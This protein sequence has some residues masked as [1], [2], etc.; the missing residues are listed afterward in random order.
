MVSSFF[1]KERPDGS[2]EEV[3]GR[4]SVDPEDVAAG[5]DSSEREE[6][7]PQNETSG[8]EREEGGPDNEEN[9]PESETEWV[10]ATPPPSLADSIAS[11][12]QSLGRSLQ[13]ESQGFRDTRVTL[14]YANP[15]GLA[16]L[17]VDHPT[18]LTTL[19]RE[20][21]SAALASEG[22]AEL[23]R[24][25][26]DLRA[27][28]GEGDVHLAIGV[29]SWDGSAGEIPVL[30]RRVAISED[31]D[32]V[33]TLQ[34]LPGVELSNP[35]VRVVREA[36]AG[37]DMEALAE[38]MNGPEGF[39]PAAALE[40]IRGAGES[41]PGFTVREGL[42]LGIYTHPAAGIYR[43]LVNL[44]TSSDH[45]VV[46]A[47]S[48]DSAA[49]A[50][51]LAGKRE[52][53]LDDRDPWHEL[54]LGDQSPKTLDVI[55]QLATGL[56]A[57]VAIPGGVGQAE[58]RASI[59]A[60]LAHGGNRVAVL[61]SNAQEHAEL[62]RTFEEAQVGSIVADLS[63]F[64]DEKVVRSRLEQIA[65]G[66]F[67]LPPNPKL[68]TGR[69]RLERAR[70]ALNDYTAALHEKFEPWGVSPF[71]ALQ[72]LTDLTSLPDPPGTT[73][74]FPMETLSTIAV[75]GGQ[76]AGELLEHASALGLF[77][78]DVPL[79]PWTGVVIDNP[80][81]VGEALAALS[82]LDQEILP[83]VRMQMV[84]TPAQSGL[85]G[86]LTLRDWA[87]QLELLTRVRAV[88]DIFDP[89]VLERSPADMVVATA[90]KQWRKAR[91]ISLKGSALRSLQ[92]QARDSVRTGVHVK[93]LHAE[94][95]TAQA[96]RHQW[97]QARSSNDAVPSVPENLDALKSSLEQLED[98]L[99]EV[100]PILEPVYGELESMP[101]DELADIVAALYGD[102]EGAA[103]I[104]ELLGVLDQLDALGLHDLALDLR[105]RGVDGE[106]L[107]LELDLAW[108]ASALG[109]MLNEDPRLGGFDPSTLTRLL[110]EARDL[111]AEQ[112]RSLGPALEQR[113]WSRGM[114]ALDLY[115][116]Q[117]QQLLERLNQGESA[118]DLFA[119]MTLPWDLMPIV[120]CGP[121]QFLDLSSV[122][123]PVNSL[124]LGDL[125]ETSPG[126]L[127]PLLAR[128]GQVIAV[129]NV[130]AASPKS[131]AATLVDALPVLEL[132]RERGGQGHVFAEI[133][134]LHERGGGE[135]IVPSP[136]ATGPFDF[137]LVE[138]RGMPSADSPAIETSTAEAATVA[139][140][141][142]AALTDH[143][144]QKLA[145]VTF[146]PRHSE[147]VALAVRK[148]AEDYPQFADAL[149]AVGGVESLLNTPADL[150]AR[151]ADR[152][153]VSVGFAKTPH[154]RVIH[155]FGELSTERGIEMM[156]DLAHGLRGHVT[157]V[158]SLR[159]N[160]VDASRLRQDGERVLVDL[161]AAAESGLT[162]L[163]EAED[164]E[165]P[166]APPHLLVDLA[167]RLHSLGLR[168]VPNFGVEGGLTIPLAIG[169]PEVPNE[170]LVAV[171]TDDESYIEEPSL[172][173]RGRH[174]PSMLEQQG[175]KVH[176]ALSMAVF[177]DPN[178]EAR[179][180]VQLAL[181]AVDEY[182]TRLGLP[183]T[184]AAASALGL[185]FTEG[186]AQG[187]LDTG[188]G[189]QAPE[190]ED[191][192][193]TE[194]DVTG[195]LTILE[196][197]ATSQE[198]LETLVGE[199]GQLESV[200]LRGP[201][202]PYEPGLPLAA[203]SDDQLDEMARWILSDGEDRDD[204]ALV[205]ELREELGI[206]RRGVQTDSVLKTVA[207]RVRR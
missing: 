193:V 66:E 8:P 14:E 44:E 32:G 69:V 144:D 89:Q 24:R 63:V 168:V 74:R 105:T 109:F 6:D 62:M 86:A 162:S 164:D 33:A 141:I 12:R 127:A 181:D 118:Q 173:V 57:V 159:A 188:G 61:V 59:T 156:Q 30:M 192:R 129:L 185:T 125:P 103:R 56:S 135:L 67:V 195:A 104:P 107:S 19:I 194:L 158:S 53:N 120:V 76:K 64:A 171:L 152:V 23:S 54:G 134:R 51:L 154:G 190:V 178:R 58:A 97:G 206:T 197:A 27:R 34:L 55:E 75:D 18:R 142:A 52:P 73:L 176:T 133:L 110:E 41:V 177:I 122:G 139:E 184:P 201:R 81:D 10:D 143:P 136:R 150:A 126:E 138:G 91:N 85:V 106:S 170:L 163:P 160:E 148:R 95:I 101:V 17:Y 167:E 93:D 29:A 187:E 202:P 100:K 147:N 196:P 203:Y 96:V 88:L 205:E 68:D 155:D 207:R 115:P 123:R 11:W 5:Q 21:E 79:S 140:L 38:S 161:L 153:I 3:E 26:Q 2:D 87:D 98:L 149:A 175:W 111:D 174:W 49:R 119:S 99:A 90:P 179:Q 42:S 31:A 204:Q 1:S 43:E 47:L 22:V 116:Q 183:H 94:L 92:R 198:S 7:S 39:L 15:G 36:G 28:Y 132:P 117:K 25:V 9:G 48:G 45:P 4:L 191:G 71:D 146:S 151:Q 172:R 124:V 78:P 13:D 102:P 165:E 128:A 60:A 157:I 200:A 186:E 108:W 37:L 182:Y 137:V 16:Q 20:P 70:G 131:A 65:S 189:S 84:V 82:H 169:H 50:S 145:V 113:V 35:L 80:E 180:I 166:Q 40:V 199:L 112:V 72:V 114:D 77:Q 121:A 130:R 83:A 46:R